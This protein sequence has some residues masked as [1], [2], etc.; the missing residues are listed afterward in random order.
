MKIACLAKYCIDPA[1]LVC[2]KATG[3]YDFERSPRKINEVDQNAVEEA[4]K[5]KTTTDCVVHIFSV[6]PTEAAKPMRELLGMGADRAFLISDPEVRNADSH[7]IADL[8]KRAIQKQGPYD[9]ILAGYAS[10]DSYAGSVALMLAEMLHMPHVAYASKISIDGQALT[11]VR[12]VDGKVETIESKLPAL[13]TVTRELNTPRYVSALQT[14]RVPRDALTTLRLS[15]L[16][17]TPEEYASTCR[18]E[19][20]ELMTVPTHRKN[21]LLD[22]ADTATAVIKLLDAL[23]DDGVL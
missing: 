19:I 21:I 22:G 3:H 4:V 6:G 16:G 2:D 10:E 5:I 17:E 15:D 11:A 7:A 12:E 18:A 23:R 14:L 9:L 8:L 1:N 20:L 13:I